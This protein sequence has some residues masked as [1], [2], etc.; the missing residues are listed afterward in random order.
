MKDKILTLLV[1]HK[2]SELRALLDNENPADLAALFTELPEAM[3]TVVFRVLPKDLAADTFVMMDSDTQEHLIKAFSDL[4]LREVLEKLFV[5][6]T[7]DI[8]EEMP[9][10]VVKKIIKNTPQEKRA[11]INEVLHY[12]ENSAGSLMTVEYVSL[13]PDMTASDA[14]KKIRRIGVNKET[15]YTCYVTDEKKVLIGIVTAKSLMLADPDDTVSEMMET[16]I[17]S[18]NTSDDGE[19]V[20]HI[21]EKYGFIALPVV[22][23]ESRLVGIITFD[24]AMYV[25]KE[26]T[27]EDIMKMAAVAPSDDSYFK[28]SV[29]AHSKNRLLWLLVLMIS[30]TFTGLIITEYENALTA[31]LVSF[32]PMLMGTAG[33]SGTQSSAI[34]IRSLATEEIR[35]KDFG[36]VVFKEFRISL[37]VGVVLALANAA[38]TWLLNVFIY[39]DPSGL[40]NEMFIV[41]ITLVGAVVTAKLLGCC[42]PMLAKRFK[43]DPALLASPLMT[44]LV[45]TITV[46]LYFSIAVSV[47]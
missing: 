20:A 5:D 19:D 8:I 14:L 46:L 31:M 47:F 42:L 33:N 17:I 18:C 4:E 2:F 1:E 37:I 13:R 27:S 25:I 6:D 12:P 11:I 15:I 9:A 3:L 38:R 40:V 16:N 24:D 23:N 22:D 32:I 7:V 39:K 10:A 44:T 29:L 28:T 21:I 34:I 45:D 35:L 41:G 30:A 36:K 43:L 26:E